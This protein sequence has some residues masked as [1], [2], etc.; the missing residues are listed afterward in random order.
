M[1]PAPGAPSRTSSGVPSTSGAS[2]TVTTVSRVGG[3]ETRWWRDATSGAAAGMVSVLALHPLDVIKTRLQVQDGVE[4]G[5]PA[6]VEVIEA[7]EMD[8]PVRN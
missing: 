1:A 2:G 8:I 7:Q 4:W 6:L 5:V 3:M